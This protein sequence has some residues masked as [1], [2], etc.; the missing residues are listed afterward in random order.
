[1]RKTLYATLVVVALVG[2]CTAA[3]HL[4]LGVVHPSQGVAPPSQQITAHPPPTTSHNAGI[5]PPA[6]QRGIDVDAYTYPKFDF[7]SAAAAVV[8]YIKQLNANSISISFPFFMSNRQSSQVFATT[9]TPT[10]TQLGLLITDAERA[11]LYV[12]IRPLLSEYQIGGNR[13][14]WQPVDI[15]AW[16]A[17]YRQFLLPYAR[18]A[19]S[20]KVGM[21]FIGAEFQRFGH[22][23]LWNSLARALAK[24]YHGRLAYSNNGSGNLSRSTG[25]Q[26]THKTVD[27]Y[28]PINPPFLSGWQTFDRGLPAGTILSEVGIGAWDG[29]WQAPWQHRQSQQQFDPRVQANWFTAACQAAKTTKLGGVYFWTLGLLPNLPPTPLHPGGWAHGAG[30]AAIARCF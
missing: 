1:M 18:I 27:A 16:F 8:A 2:G 25:G 21:F 12:S 26:Y 30:A 3:A 10:P 20:R 17:S 13:T 6:F 5:R 23:T 19:Q 28:P 15:S 4:D 11:G 14:T 7:S 22:S 24:V 9:K 29:A